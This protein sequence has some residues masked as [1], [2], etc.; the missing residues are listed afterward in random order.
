MR[1]AEP[2]GS[3]CTVIVIADVVAG[4]QGQVHSLDGLISARFRQT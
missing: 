1:I 4:M 3:Y 2:F